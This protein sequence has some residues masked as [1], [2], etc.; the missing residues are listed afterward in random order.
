MK[1]RKLKGENSKELFTRTKFYSVHIKGMIEKVNDL[2]LYSDS[3]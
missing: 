1:T 2:S 3:N